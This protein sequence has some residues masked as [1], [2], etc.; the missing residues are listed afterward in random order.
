M[1]KKKPNAK[2]TLMCTSKKHLA[3]VQNLRNNDTFFTVFR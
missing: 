1:N 2:I 3:S